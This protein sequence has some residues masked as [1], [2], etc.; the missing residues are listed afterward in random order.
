[1]TPQTL[2]SNLQQILYLALID[3]AGRVLVSSRGFTPQ[4][5]SELLQPATLTLLRSARPYASGN[6]LPYDG[7]G[8]VDLAVSFPTRY[9]RRILLS[10]ISP[11][12]LG[13]FLAGDLRRIPGVKGA[14]NYVLD[15]GDAVLGSNNPAKPVGYKFVEPSQVVALSRG[16]GDLGGYYYD[17]VAIPNSTWRVV[18][19]APDGPLFTSVSGLAQVGAV[20]DLDRLRA[21]RGSGVGA[22]E[23][24]APIGRAKRGRRLQGVGDEVRPRGEH[25][26]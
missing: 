4:A 1:M 26:P 19:S 9:G 16:S 13:A 14:H 18:L 15:G 5:R 10:G 21:G 2:D 17:Q 6:L 22:R 7:T 11:V 25:E 12:T 8:V 24:C 20:A 3:P 23:A